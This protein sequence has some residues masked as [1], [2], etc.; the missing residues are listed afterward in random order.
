M[1]SII[2]IQTIENMIY[3]IRGQK[4]M[5]DR[6]LAQLY[7]VK[8]YRLN[9]AVKRNIKR[10]PPEFMFQLNEDEKKELIAFCDRFKT[11]VHSTSNPYA[12]TEHGVVMLASVLNS[13]LAIAINV[14]VV[15][16]FVKLREI[17]LSHKELAVQL[18]EIEK[19]FMDYRRENYF[20]QKE[21][22]DKIEELYQCIQYLVDIHKPGKIGFKTE[23]Q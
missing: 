3:T 10:F 15:K 20:E 22:N 7:S 17:A 6:D 16:T 13:E 8:T 1:Q 21:Q 23:E 2:P 11:L 9:E 18:N 12:F 5:I 14:Q 19:R 4:V